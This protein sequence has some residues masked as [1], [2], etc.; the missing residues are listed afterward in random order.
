[1]TYTHAH[2]QT[3]FMANHYVA[4]GLEVPYIH[5]PVIPYNQVLPQ[6]SPGWWVRPVHQQATVRI[7]VVLVNQNQN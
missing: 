6:V 4:S 7:S 1:M 5:F 2:T 3:M